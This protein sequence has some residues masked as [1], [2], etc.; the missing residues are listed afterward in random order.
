MFLIISA[1]GGG[2]LASP[3][4]KP[5]LYRDGVWGSQ[6]IPRGPLLVYNSVY[7]EVTRIADAEGLVGRY[8]AYGAEVLLQ[9]NLRGDH[10]AEVR[11]G[12]VRA[13]E[14]L[15]RVLEGR[16]KGE[17]CRVEDVDVEVGVDGVNDA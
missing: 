5:L 10:L 17:G 11:N 3:L 2:F 8:C 1:L 15:E 13:R 16:Y 4:V 12:R 7:D 14:F 9:R 6:G